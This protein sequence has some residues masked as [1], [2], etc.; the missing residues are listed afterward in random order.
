MAESLGAAQTRVAVQNRT[1]F[2]IRKGDDDCGA[3]H[4]RQTPDVPGRYSVPRCDHYVSLHHH[5]TYSYL[6]GVGLPEVHVRRAAE[7][8]MQALA[9][10]EHGNISSHVKLE[11][12]G[13][14]HG[15]KPIF[16]CELYTGGT[17]EGKK[18]QLKN[19]LTVLAT[20]QAGYRNLLRLVT[21][22]W[23]QFY[24][25][26]TASPKDIL[27][28]KEGL[29]VLSGCTGSQ[30][31]TSLVGG[32][33]VPVAEAGYS[34]GKAV[35]AAYQREFGDSYYLEVQAFPELEN[36]RRLNA[37]LERISNETGI[38]L[39]AT[40]DV[41]YTQPYE[42]ELQKILHNVRGGG[43]KTLEEMS[44]EWGYDVPLSPPTSDRY[45][46]HR[47]RATGLSH[48]AAIQAVLNTEAIA[49]RCN[50][51]LPKMEMVRF[52]VP[53][54][55]NTAYE[56]WRAELKR[57][58]AFRNIDDRPGRHRYAAALRHEMKVIEE[59]D[60]I[61]YFLIVADLITYA[62]DHGIPVGP[63][64]GSSAASLACYLLRITEVDPFQF[65]N[66]LFER[67]I[68]PTRKDLP[69]IDIDFA[70]D[71]RYEV[72][73]YAEAKYGRENVGNI[74]SFTQYKS[75]LALDDVAR[76]YRIPKF[77]VEAVKELLVER[78]S[79][80]LRADAT[81]EDTVAMFEAA[82][83]IF[84][85]HP[86]LVHAVD[87][88]G[89]VKGMG[90]HAAGMVV[91][92]S[93]LTESCAT[94]SRTMG[95]GRVL[96]VL[97]VD[98]Y[99]AE[100][101]N[102]L[103]IDSLGLTTLGMINKALRLIGKPLSWLYEIPLDDKETINGFREADCVGI[104]QFDGRAMRGVTAEL[105]PDNFLEVADITALA[106]PG[107]LHNGA[108]AEYIDVKKGRKAARQYHPKVAAITDYTHGQIVYQ[109][110]ILRITG[111]IG[112]FDHTHRATIRRIISKKLGEQEFNSWWERFRDGAVERGVTEKEAKEIWNAC[113]TAGSYAFNV[114]H[115]ISYGL[116]AWWTMFLKRHYPEA[117][118]TASLAA[119]GDK[120]QLELL[121]DASRHGITVAP[122]DLNASGI[123]WSYQEGRIIG[124]LSQVK[125]IGAKTAE[126]IIDYRTEHGLDD[127]AGILAI[128]GIGKKK[129]ET[130]LDF[131]ASDDP[132]DIFKLERK[133]ADAKAEARKHYYLPRPTHTADKI[134]YSRGQDTAVTWMGVIT[135]RNLK[136]LFEVHFSRT[137]EELDRDSVKAPELNEWV[138]M[139]G[140]D[141]TDN[142]YITV[143][144]FN[145][146]RLREAVWGVKLGEDVVLVRGT[147]KGNQSRKA[148]YVQDIWVFG[149]DE[150]EEA[151]P[152]LTDVA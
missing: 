12:A 87:L 82:A 136:E 67:F 72:Q 21:R 48:K 27:E 133:I 55:Y 80:D 2:T 148:I 143:D 92:S 34:R 89:N 141:G 126:Q 39:V 134:P 85:E 73:A 146:A 45:I 57:G 54:G 83:K 75:K 96:S 22:S 124:G 31:A 117:F 56:F 49:S 144:R 116:L 23:D 114:P 40:G 64:R 1:G 86:D 104:F 101:L 53:E 90:V 137:G 77:K 8:G 128:K 41:H 62:K 152:L 100:H 68:D 36:V 78:S 135:K 130:I 35:A 131:V 74:G 81:I 97:S 28:Y 122:P 11:K 129:L 149:D 147:K 84:E 32:K 107:P 95:D 4:A 145:Y 29:I 63:G 125:G 127:W 47:L 9:V 58:W 123:S 18:G 119:Y 70:D 106:R 99:D 50:V 112:G 115:A 20:D 33:N 25:A 110:Q 71:R 37:M 26:P 109:E 93:P 111:E 16:G 118:Y 60:F 103:K 15:V 24:Y 19:H 61:E 98:K 59:K 43:K 102:V 150:E 3:T 10:T 46:Y 66:L 139:W 151:E 120:K 51:E 138:V 7:L 142:L 113:I 30:L 13:Q 65:P 91:S 52:P 79:G 108:A 14:E 69:D 76:V 88:E 6:D 140:D 38:P 121:R 44:R 17:T 132:Y 5:T 42:S 94:Y 105:Q